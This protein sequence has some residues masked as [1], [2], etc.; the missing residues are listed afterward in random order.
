[1]QKFMGIVIAIAAIPLILTVG[2]TGHHEALACQYGCNAIPCVNP[3]PS[4]GYGCCSCPYAWNAPPPPPPPVVVPYGYGAPS[5]QQGWSGQEQGASINQYGNGN[6][7][8]IGQNQ[9]SV[10]NIIRNFGQDWLAGWH[11][12]SGIG[13]SLGGFGGGGGGYNGYGNGQ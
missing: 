7:A 1:M 2:L 6:Y 10:M 11:T 8:S 13:N 3:S 12:L 4:W 5:Y 9:D